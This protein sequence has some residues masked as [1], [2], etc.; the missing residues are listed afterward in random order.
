MTTTQ[1]MLPFTSLDD[2]LGALDGIVRI[3]AGGGPAQA[4]VE[5]LDAAGF[6]DR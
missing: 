1:P 2:L 6:R 3:D 5:I 4:G